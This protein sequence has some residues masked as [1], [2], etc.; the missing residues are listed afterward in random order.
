MCCCATGGSRLSLESE[1]WNDTN[2]PEP[3]SPESLSNYIERIQDTSD[4]TGPKMA[5]TLTPYVHTQPLHKSTH[6][7]PLLLLKTPRFCGV[8]EPVSYPAS[9]L[10][11]QFACLTEPSLLQPFMSDETCQSKAESRSSAQISAATSS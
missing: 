8:N 7:P 4:I 9:V 10:T 3:H 6:T 11:E 2:L 5:H 1:L